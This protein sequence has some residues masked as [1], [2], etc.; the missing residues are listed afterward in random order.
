VA[1][2]EDHDAVV[3]VV[4]DDGPGV[5]GEIRG[6]IFDPF[7]TTKEVGDGTGLGLSV[8]YGI[9]NEHGGSLFHEAPAGGGARFVLRLPR[10]DTA[11]R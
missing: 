2:R 1:C 6:Q 7:F 8:S 4:E 9:V 10:D 5:P 11:G 3:Y